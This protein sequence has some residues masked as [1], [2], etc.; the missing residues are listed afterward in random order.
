MSSLLVL[1]ELL[2]KI[3]R[4]REGGRGWTRITSTKSI[5]I[6]FLALVLKF[7]FPSCVKLQLRR[8]VE[9]GDK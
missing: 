5:S 2:G 3:L 6:Y 1:S 8:L 4:S 9:K 7:L